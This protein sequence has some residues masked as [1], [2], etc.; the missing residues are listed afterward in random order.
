M[1]IATAV[2]TCLVQKYADFNGRASLAEF[3]W[4]ALFAIALRVVGHIV[5]RHGAMGLITLALVLP[6]MAVTARRLHDTGRSGWLQLLWIVPVIGWAILIYL[7]AQPS[8]PQANHYGPPPP[9]D[10]PVTA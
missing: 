6:W 10:A 3:W 7:A 1:D 2:K 9:S 4:F 5:F 8:A